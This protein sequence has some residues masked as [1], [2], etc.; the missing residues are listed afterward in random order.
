M[1]EP[2]VEVL[3]S[4]YNGER[5]L[6]EQVAS[7]LRQTHARLRLLVRDDGSTDRT[8]DVLSAAPDDRLVVRRGGNL[9]LPAAFFRLIDESSD[10]ADYWALADQDDVWVEQKLARAVAALDALSSE[11]ALYC[12]RVQVVDEQLT[13][14]YPHE[15]PRRGPSFANA[16]VQNIALGCTIVFNPAARDVLRG[17]WPRDCV[18]HDAWLY[19]VVAGTGTVVYDDE[20]AVFYRQHGRNVVGMGRDPVSRFAGRVRRQLSHSGA[21]GHG[22]QDAELKRLHGERLSPEAR[23][24]LVDFLAAQ[25]SLGRR[26]RYAIFGAAHRQTRG[27]DAVLRVLQVLGRV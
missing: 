4:T 7:V 27:S 9:G 1:P 21:G 17:R 3:M 6:A 15:L 25:R 13:P 26:V 24:Q 11:P 8:V 19:L 14:L 16:L 18:M 10:D 22:R 5:Y 20:I 23:T 12:A 2:L